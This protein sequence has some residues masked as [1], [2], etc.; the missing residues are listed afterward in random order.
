MG[1]SKYTFILQKNPTNW[2]KLVD[3]FPRMMVKM[4]NETRII[5][6]VE[7]ACESKTKVVNSHNVHFPVLSAWLLAAACSSKDVVDEACR[8]PYC[9]L[10]SRVWLLMGARGIDVT[11]GYA[12]GLKMS[13]A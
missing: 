10:G 13:E 1:V 7:M 5:T 2:I 8:P 6:F 9:L 3:V 11:S 12:I 4:N